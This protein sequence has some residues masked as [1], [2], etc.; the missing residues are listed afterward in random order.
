VVRVGL[1]RLKAALSAFDLDESSSALDQ[2]AAL[3]VTA[4]VGDAVARVRRLVDSYEYEEACETV[5]RLLA[6]LKEGGSA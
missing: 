2:V 6:G 1:E 3:S 5:T 4:E